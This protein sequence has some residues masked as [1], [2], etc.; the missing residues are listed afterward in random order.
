MCGLEGGFFYPEYVCNDFVKYEGQEVRDCL[1]A[2]VS[3]FQ[4]GYISC[5][6]V[7]TV[8]REQCYERF[9]QKNEI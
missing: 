8:G 9:V 3:V 5:S 2:V 1:G 4:D 7:D 6:L